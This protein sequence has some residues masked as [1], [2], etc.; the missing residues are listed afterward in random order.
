V[1]N[2]K[3][4]KGDTLPLRIEITPAE[5]EDFSDAQA[6]FT[7]KANATDS[8]AAAVLAD[9]QPMQYDSANNVWFAAFRF[10]GGL[11]GKKDTRALIPGKQYPCDVQLVYQNGYV[12]PDIETSLGITL[13]VE[14]DI[15]VGTT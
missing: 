4:P 11:A 14:Q 1:A 15:S 13:E 5:G 8:D 9:K 6:F 10:S 3:F 12:D 7:C 2:Y